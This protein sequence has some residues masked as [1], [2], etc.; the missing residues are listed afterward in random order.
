MTSATNR[1]DPRTM[2]SVMGKYFMNSPMSPGQKARGVKAARVVPVEAMMGHATS[3]TP[4]LAA[5]KGEK[6]S[7]MKRYTFSTTTI[8]LSTNIP[9]ARTNAKRTIVLN[10]IPMAPRIMKLINID[11]GIATPTKSAFLRPRK[12]NNTPTTKRIPKMIEF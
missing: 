11:R 5:S 8:P 3:P 9:N 10:V 7:S 6:P 4:Y 1:E 12:N 2:M